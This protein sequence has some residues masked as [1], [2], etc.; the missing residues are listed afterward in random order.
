MELT[1]LSQQNDNQ[2]VTRLKQR[3]AEL[4]EQLAL[5]QTENPVQINQEVQEVRDYLNNVFVQSP[6]PFAIT[7][8]P[9]HIFE[10]VNVR[11]EQLSGKQELIGKS[12]REVFPEFEGQG[13]AER[14]DEVYRT[15]QPFYTP[16]F[17][18]KIARSDGILEERFFNLTYQ[19]I[20]NLQGQ[21]EGI[22]QVGFEL[23]AQIQ[24]QQALQ[25][26]EG[27]LHLITN[28]LPVLISYVDKEQRYR[29]NNK[30][31]EDWFGHSR[32]EV[33]GKHLE[34]LL[35]SE[36]Y[37]V[38]RPYAE[39]ALAGQTV[40]YHSV[41]PYKD[42]G[43]R[44]IEA[45]Y[46]PD[47]DEQG[48]VKGF[49]A[50]VVDASER[51]RDEENERFLAQASNLLGT[52]LDYDTTL[53]NVA[54][55]IVPFLADWCSIDLVDE[56][57]GFRRVASSHVNPGKQAIVHTLF[58]HYPYE[59]G[60]THPFK[61]LLHTGRSQ[62][63]PELSEQ[64][65]SLIARS[66]EH[67]QILRELDLKSGM[68][69]PLVVRGQIIGAFTLA[70]TES[71]R[72]YSQ[73]DLKLAEEVAHRAATA[74][75]NARLYQE[76]QTAIQNRSEFLSIAAHELKTPLT[77]LQGYVQLL[78]RQ[79]TKTGQLDPVRV[80]RA[81]QAIS[82]QSSKLN[83]LLSQLLDVSRIE[84][85][86]LLLEP[87]VTNLVPLVETVVA[88]AQATT[89]EHTLTFT[90]PAELEALL[91]PVRFEQVVVNLID[92][93][94]K[95]SPQGG[96]IGVELQLAPA[97]TICL[98]VTDR[99]IGIPAPH[100]AHIF[101][102]FYQAHDGNYLKGMGLG[103]HISREIVELHG[104]RI[105]VETPE[106]GGTRFVVYLPLTYDPAAG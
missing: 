42:G 3:I 90:A 33:A 96:P 43:T 87:V 75:D 98:T 40:T 30:G 77:G 83:K 38:V 37:K 17:P 6:M 67:L 20:R 97:T 13:V 89:T 71:D 105:E 50:L 72:R 95:Y 36:G 16:Q 79:L 8:G 106:G 34:E 2:E 64:Q 62:F 32:A 59:P 23:T 70:I 29:F 9:G 51:K 28:S 53:H 55:L 19:P 61:E 88:T 60:K 86:R 56:Q 39:Q 102:R 48:Q 92:N 22:I 47:F 99:G 65:L 76:A 35:G 31:Y 81:L 63:F 103:L 101:D 66:P 104:G 80:E 25:R 10:L 11:Y 4:E 82:Q 52:T 57:K 54:Q 14:L 94:I 69:V 73:I 1:N 100:R 21:V 78:M 41:V 58:E 93:A 49:V 46:V 18:V 12:L 27:Q 26:S 85:G 24:A 45:S 68:T 5:V 91:D 7:K 74:M 84:A 44:F 15:G